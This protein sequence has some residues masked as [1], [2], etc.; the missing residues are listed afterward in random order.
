MLMQS[1]HSE[2]PNVFFVQVPFCRAVGLLGSSGLG[3]GSKLS[4][5]Y[6]LS[7]G[8]RRAEPHVTP[9]PFTRKPWPWTLGRADLSATGRASAESTVPAP[10][11]PTAVDPAAPE[12]DPWDEGS[13]GSLTPPPPGKCRP[14][15]GTCPCPGGALQAWCSSLTGPGIVG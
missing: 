13:P 3:S 14:L 4:E 5:S 12:G 15:T 11:V 9:V 10:Q 6:P 2:K 1:A 7:P 8:P